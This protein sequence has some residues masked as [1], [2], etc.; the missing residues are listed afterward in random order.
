MS[1]SSPDA[2]RVAVWMAMAEHFLDTETRHD[3]PTTARRCVEAGMTISEARDVWRY[4]VT[5]A[6]CF[7]VLSVAGEWAY[8]DRD[9]LVARIERLRHGWWNRLAGARWLH[10]PF[11]AGNWRAIEQCMNLLWSV[12]APNQRAVLAQDLTFLA[13]HCF[14]FCPDRA[15]ELDAEA[16]ARLRDLCPQP[17]L[18]LVEPALLSSERLAAKR[19]L[20]AV[21]EDLAR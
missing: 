1:K 11:L 18:Q 12:P 10:W 2:D 6:V 14:D 7:N 13:R 19:R 4:E 3:L 5:P 16:R 9:W 21:L 17:I 8:W 15:A 20:E